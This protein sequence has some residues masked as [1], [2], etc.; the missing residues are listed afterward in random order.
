M[1]W[2]ASANLNPMASKSSA[3]SPDRATHRNAERHGAG[4]YLGDIT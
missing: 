4:T 1:Q 3:E 2:I